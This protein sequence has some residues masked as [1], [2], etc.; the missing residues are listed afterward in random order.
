MTRR[1]TTA[2]LAVVLATLLLAGVSTLVVANVRARHLTEI[3]LRRQA[4]GIAS[5]LAVALNDDQIVN[6]RVNNEAQA[7]R[8]RVLI[9]ATL[10]RVFQLQDLA[11]VTIGARG[12]LGGDELP[13]RIRLK[14]KAIA[15]LGALV[16]VS[17]NQG[18][19]V[20]AAAPTPLT[21]RTQLV[22]VITRRANSGLA[23]SLR[24][25]LLA[26]I[27]TL[28]IGASAALVL[29]RKLTAPI[30]RAS[31]AAT[32]IAHGELSTRL[33]Q[34]A[35]SE[36][37]EVAELT[38]SINSMAVEL[39]RSRTLE[40]QFLL[41]IT[42]DLRTP[43]TSIRGYADAIRDGAVEPNRAA[44]V[45][46]NE[47]R[48]LERL[49]SDLLD[50]SKLRSSGF[51]LDPQ[52]IDI[53][54]LVKMSVERCLPEAFESAISVTSTANGRLDISAD[55]D[56][57]SQIMANLLD[58]ALKYAAANVTVDLIHDGADVVIGVDDDG[59]GIDP[60]DL[61]FVFDRLYV[62]RTR[63]KRRENDSGLG[64]AIV[65]ELVQAMGGRVIASTSHL[66]GA[67]FVLRIPVVGTR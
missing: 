2:F 36:H 14:P 18:D 63:P 60:A 8:R 22:V 41:S 38:R 49:V 15:D 59:P 20:F 1:L 12:K 65:K 26:A 27:A 17:G 4:E 35:S 24:T 31:V 50:L 33:V 34:P 48:R 44:T 62:S 21:G 52:T 54:A 55:H 67:R 6:G 61:P 13:A 58:N 29:G 53:V 25:F 19:L 32:R 7:T 40:Q 64:L 5:N 30:R 23:A 16:I 43:L 39:D 11:I 51:S 57:M 46:H 66:G 37:D 42:H 56:R 9:L 47:S 28:A 45:I 10:R 3:E